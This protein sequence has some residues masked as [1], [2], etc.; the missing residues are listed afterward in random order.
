MG[1]FGK[2]PAAKKV[3][4]SSEKKKPFG[5]YSINFNGCT[6]TMEEVFGK[7]DIAP[8]EMTKKIWAYVKD[9]KIAGKK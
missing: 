7:K 4:K 9:N 6:E 5:G 2:K 8:S 3:A 1:L